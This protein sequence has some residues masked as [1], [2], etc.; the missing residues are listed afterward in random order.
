VLESL[1]WGLTVTP[2]VVWVVSHNRV[3]HAHTG[4]PADC[5]RYF[6]RSERSRVRTWFALLFMPNQHLRWNPLVFQIFLVEMTM[7]ALAALWY[8]GRHAGA[9]G[10]IPR[11]G[12]YTARD[13]LR[14][15][16]ELA[17]I[18]AF[19]VGLYFAV[20]ADPMRYLVAGPAAFLIASAGASAYL[21]TQH[22]LHDVTARSDPFSSTSVRVPAL[23]DWLHSYH[24]H[25]TAH[26]LLPVLR[27]QYYPRVTELLLRDHPARMQRLGFGACLARAFDNPTYKADPIIARG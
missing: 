7:H 21:Y 26:H 12:V 4:S 5:F 11:L 3:H 17:G 8:A 22:T 15:L 6:T 24:S 1:L 18:A 25:H 19:Q 9:V 14:L 13:R 2:A 23:I 16:A 20:G 10:P 27:C